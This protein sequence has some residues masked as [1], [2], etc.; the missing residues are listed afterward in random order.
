MNFRQKVAIA[1][2][3]WSEEDCRLF[4]KIG[5]KRDQIIADY[6]LKQKKF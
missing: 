2:K 1:F 3:T 6:V 5:G 4:K